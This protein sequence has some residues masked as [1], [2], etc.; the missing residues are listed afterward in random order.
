MWIP[1]CHRVRLSVVNAEFQWDIFF[2]RKD[3]RAGL[4]CISRLNRFFSE[5]LVYLFCSNLPC[6]WACEVPV[7]VNETYIPDRQFDLMP[8]CLDEAK[9]LI[10]NAFE[11]GS[12]C[13]NSS[14]CIRYLSGMIISFLES[15]VTLASSSCVTCSWFNI[16]WNLSTWC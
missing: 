12:S 4:I 2:R 8:R 10:A 5:H 6:W 14:L 13:R 9:M 3:S 1:H 15:S 16:Y 11:F 7:V